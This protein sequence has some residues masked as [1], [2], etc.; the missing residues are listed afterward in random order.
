VEIE[1]F[2]RRARSSF[3]FA[4]NI[5]R[6]LTFP[7]RLQRAAR[8][9]RHAAS[10]FPVDGAKCLVAKEL[11]VARLGDRIRKGRDCDALLRDKLHCAPE[12]CEVTMR[13]CCCYET[14]H[15]SD[16]VRKGAARF[17]HLNNKAYFGAWGAG[18]VS[19]AE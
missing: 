11:R 10:R 2:V 6:E 18:S 3:F 13:W 16:Q 15:H 12:R 7:P 14:N 17:A 19:S 1:C 8:E 9:R 5:E 4:K